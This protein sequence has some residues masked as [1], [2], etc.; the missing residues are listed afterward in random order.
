MKI[1]RNLILLGLLFVAGCILLGFVILIYPGAQWPSPRLY[2]EANAI[3][4]EGAVGSWGLGRTQTY[5]INQSA[6][7]LQAHYELEMAKYCV[8]DW[9][10]TSLPSGDYVGGNRWGLDELPSFA[11]KGGCLEASCP[12]YRWNMDQGFRVLIC[13]ESKTR[14]IIVQVD[15]WE[16]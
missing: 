5:T 14:S 11:D 2:P 1:I 3:V 16:D 6:D 15:E 4:S 12:I 7:I 9:Q 10:F 8:E 13:E